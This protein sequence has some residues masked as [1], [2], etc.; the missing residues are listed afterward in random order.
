MSEKLPEPLC[1]KH[2][3]KMSC[4]ALPFAVSPVY[5][6]GVQD[7]RRHYGRRLGYFYPLKPPLH[8]DPIDRCLKD[9]PE[10]GQEHS[11][12]AITYRKDGS[13]WYC[14]DCRRDY[15]AHSSK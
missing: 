4:E 8:I 15:G 10:K 9:C 2:I 5:V 12:M 11:Y 7:C 13:G 1:D 3:S 14:F 6:C